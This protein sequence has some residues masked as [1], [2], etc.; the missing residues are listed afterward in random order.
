MIR[1]ALAVPSDNKLPN[2]MFRQF[3][4]R[5][6]EEKFGQHNINWWNYDGVF[7]FRNEADATLFLLRWS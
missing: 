1:I 5:W 3:Y 6:C 2:V 4:H 7:T